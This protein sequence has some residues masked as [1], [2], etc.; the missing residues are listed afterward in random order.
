[1]GSN[2]IVVSVHIPSLST[3]LLMVWQPLKEV[4]ITAEILIKQ[5]E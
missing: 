3:K 2:Y 1:M 5:V 4:T